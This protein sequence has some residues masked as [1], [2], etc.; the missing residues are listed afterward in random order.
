MSRNAITATISTIVTSLAMGLLVSTNAV[1]LSITSTLTPTLIVPKPAALPTIQYPVCYTVQFDSNA[2]MLSGT[3]YQ[4]RCAEGEKQG[5]IK[6]V[7]V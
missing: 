4:R 2:G 6:V 7:T 3:Y 5:S 1:A